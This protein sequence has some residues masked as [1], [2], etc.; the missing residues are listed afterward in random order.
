MRTRCALIT[1]WGKR[2]RLEEVEWELILLPLIVGPV[3][4]TDNMLLDQ[5]QLIRAIQKPHL[6]QLL[7]E[8]A[9]R[10]LVQVWHRPGFDGDRRVGRLEDVLKD[11]L[12]RKGDQVA[13]VDFGSLGTCRDPRNEGLRELISGF[14][15]VGDHERLVQFY[16]YIET[17]LPG[18]HETV[19]YLDEIFFEDND[20]GAISWAQYPE[21]LQYRVLDALG[22]PKPHELTAKAGES[23]K[24]LWELLDAS[25]MEERR[26][27]INWREFFYNAE[28][29]GP[30]AEFLERLV[31]DGDPGL[32]PLYDIAERVGEENPTTGRVLTN[33]AGAAYWS[34]IA[35]ANR[36]RVIWPWMLGREP[37]WES[38][39]NLPDECDEI[40]GMVLRGAQRRPEILEAASDLAMHSER[41]P[42][43]DLSEFLEDHLGQLQSTVFEGLRA[44]PSD[45]QRKAAGGLGAYAGLG[46]ASVAT[47]IFPQLAALREQADGV[48]AA[49]GVGSLENLSRKAGEKLLTVVYP[50]LLGREA[51]Y[52][53]QGASFYRRGSAV[54]DRVIHFHD[55]T[56]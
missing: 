39:V 21:Q 17:Y 11:W 2:L 7:Q 31:Q 25:S 32:T 10:G 9:R 54:I 28:H 3:A 18:F 13:T 49:I 22:F 16:S 48:L 38:G 42:T 19:R 43:G 26:L 51:M 40:A 53:R 33:V 46:I 24:A 29:G 52:G 45:Q 47:H 41:V 20:R 30:E 50:R 55:R 23:R 37:T 34:G 35:E 44:E 14:G 56:S 36:K 12:Y 8:Y 15:D 1:T 5:P 27:Q 6:R 4:F